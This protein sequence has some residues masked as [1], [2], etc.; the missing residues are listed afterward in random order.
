MN[1]VATRQETAVTSGV[2]DKPVQ[3]REAWRLLQADF[4]DKK[5]I[6]ADRWRLLAV[7]FESVPDELLARAVLNYLAKEPP[8][9]FPR[10]SDLAEMIRQLKQPTPFEIFRKK[11]ANLGYR[12]IDETAEGNFTVN[13][14]TDGVN[15]G[16]VYR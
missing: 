3:M 15:T 4:S 14:F 7:A 13:T 1:A 16:T 8:V 10:V 6:T 5:D 9:F 12:M 11:M 2:L